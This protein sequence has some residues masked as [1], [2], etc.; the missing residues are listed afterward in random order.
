M[1][2]VGDLGLKKRLFD[3]FIGFSNSN[4]AHCR[5]IAQYFILKVLQDPTFASFVESGL[6]PMLNYLRQ[7]KDTQRIT[8]KFHVEL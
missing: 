8:D 3:K 7:N 5:S 6:E 4:H 1:D 2:K